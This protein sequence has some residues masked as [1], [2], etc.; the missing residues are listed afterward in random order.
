MVAWPHLLTFSPLHLL[1]IHNFN[2]ISINNNI[3]TR[4][5]SSILCQITNTEFILNE[6]LFNSF[7]NAFTFPPNRTRGCRIAT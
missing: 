2:Y 6:K 1:N 5:P 3:F 4:I 7:I